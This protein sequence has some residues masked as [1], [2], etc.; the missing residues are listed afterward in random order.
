[1]SKGMEVSEIL[2]RA[3]ATSRLESLTALMRKLTELSQA[4]R[5][6]VDVMLELYDFSAELSRAE[7]EA[8][9]DAE[10]MFNAYHGLLQ[11]DNV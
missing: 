1:M 5:I 11:G 4:E 10:A 7:Y 9:A 3:K 8:Q 6:S 2:W